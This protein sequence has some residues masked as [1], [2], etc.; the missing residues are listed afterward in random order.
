MI[1]QYN[2]ME[3]NAAQYG[4]YPAKVARDRVTDEYAPVKVLVPD[5][6]VFNFPN[7]VTDD[8]LEGLGAGARAV[9]PRREGPEVRRSRADVGHVPGQP[10]HELGS[11]VEAKTGKGR[12]IYLGLAL[13]RQVPAEVEGAYQLL[14]NLISL[15]KAP[16]APAAA[17]PAA[18]VKK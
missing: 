12:W 7:K 15:P 14:A 10:R 9:L 4:P 5:H 17:R 13:W 2:K 11:L 8:D 18:P 16:A 6:P 3:F 1:I